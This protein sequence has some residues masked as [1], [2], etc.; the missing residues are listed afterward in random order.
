MRADGHGAIFGPGRVDGP[1][2]EYYEPLECPV[3]EHP[4]SKQLHNPT[5]LHFAAE[6]K[7]VCDPRFPFICTT[8]RVTEHWQTGLMTRYQGW[9]VE[10]EPQMF[11]EM[12]EELAELRGIQNGEKVWLESA[13]GKVWAKAI[14]TK[15]IKPFTVMGQ[16]VHL[17]GIPW[18]Y[19]WITP[20]NGGDSANLLI[21]AVGDPNTGI[22]ESKAF[23]V[24]VTKA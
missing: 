2:P 24:N 6:E 12:S 19:G 15:R 21:P 14:V 11:C 18:H 22:P 5:A 8:Y 1:F 9:L 20:K 23:M 7:A 4:F 10:A 16:T 13:R 17:V 3:I